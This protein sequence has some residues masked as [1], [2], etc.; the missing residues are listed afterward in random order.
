MEPA[1]RN[2]YKRMVFA[3]H[4]CYPGEVT[5]A[6][7][8]LR[9]AFQR[10][11]GKVVPKEEMIRRVERGEFILKEIIALGKL[12]KYRTMARQYRDEDEDV[13]MEKPKEMK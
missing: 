12:H 5:R 9:S 8:Q 2:L 7:E 3:I 13:K 4:S 6:R 10:N 1:V 11:R